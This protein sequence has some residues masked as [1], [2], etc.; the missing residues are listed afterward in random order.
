[1][2]EALRRQQS[3]LG[4]RGRKM[5]MR[6]S[7]QGL[8]ASVV[9]VHLGHRITQKMVPGREDRRSHIVAHGPTEN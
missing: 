5:D 7:Q 4:V 3:V 9:G 1:M 6:L 8:S 2:L